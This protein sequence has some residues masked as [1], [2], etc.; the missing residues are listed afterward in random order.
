MGT[1]FKKKKRKIH[2]YRIIFIIII[3]LIIVTIIKNIKQKEKAQASN[4]TIEVSGNLL[5]NQTEIENEIENK[6]VN[7]TNNE[8]NTEPTNTTTNEIIDSIENSPELDWK[9]TLAN[10]DN[11]IPEDYEVNLVSID[12]YR[13]FDSRAI[14]N[15]QNM[16][17]GLRKDGITDVWVQSAY[18]S[19]KEQEEVYNSKVKFYQNQGKTLEEAKELTER[20]INKPGCSDHNLGLA[21]DFN[22]VNNSFEKT[23][24][25][26][27]LKENAE[28]YG[29]VLR[30]PKEK[31]S[32]TK[33]NYEPWHW[34]YV[35]EENA[36]KMNELNYCLEEYVEF[37]KE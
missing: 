25:F 2:L 30:Y 29:F 8:D 10:S 21:V 13:E 19:V 15:L 23:K 14:K 17:N 18:R 34:R 1:R 20:I 24:A 7:E 22:Y 11:P 37:L 12:E 4:N 35:G 9:L 3:A 36:K 6:I 26:K 32:I 31:E 28:N 16:L 27:W 5:S 33:V